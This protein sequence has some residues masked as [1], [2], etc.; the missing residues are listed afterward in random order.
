M[1]T[2]E[3]VLTDDEI[4]GLIRTCSR[5]SSGEI[6]GTGMYRLTRRVEAAVLAKVADGWI[7]VEHRMPPA[8]LADTK[9]SGNG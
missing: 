1:T 7:S 9:E 6:S 8:A 3:R 5:D 2:T 4:D